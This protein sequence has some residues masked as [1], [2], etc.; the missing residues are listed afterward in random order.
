MGIALGLLS[1]IP[2]LL[3]TP[4]VK[5]PTFPALLV[6]LIITSLFFSLLGIS[7][8][9]PPKVK[10]WALAVGNGFVSSVV[11]RIIFDVVVEPRSHNI[12]P[13]EIVAAM[14]ISAPFVYA[15][16]Y[17]GKKLSWVETKTVT[18]G[19]IKN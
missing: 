7:Y 9:A 2:Y 5:S 12:F 16:A 10:R 13:F 8:Y 11:L 14:L 4:R 18:G 19:P 3:A 15:G 17:A 1:G 6:L